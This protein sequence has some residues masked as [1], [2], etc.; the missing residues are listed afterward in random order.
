MR[1]D[2]V[3][4]IGNVNRVEMTGTNMVCF[5]SCISIFCVCDGKIHDHK[6]YKCFMSDSTVCV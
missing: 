1:V 4:S 3:L 2:R 5:V 6:K